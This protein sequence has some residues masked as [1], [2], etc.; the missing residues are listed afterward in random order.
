MT[1]RLSPSAPCA[2][3]SNRSRPEVKPVLMVL[4]GVVDKAALRDIGAVPHRAGGHGH[5]QRRLAPLDRWR[6][7]HARR[8]GPDTPSDVSAEMDVATWTDIVAGRAR[9][10][11]RSSTDASRSRATLNE[12]PQVRQS[13][14]GRCP[15][16][17]EARR[18]GCRRAEK[19]RRAWSTGL[20]S[21]ETRFTPPHAAAAASS[22]R[23]RSRARSGARSTTWA[24]RSRSSASSSRRPRASLASD[25]AHEFRLPGFRSGRSVP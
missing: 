16:L 17:I 5:R 3:A 13:A 23:W 25:V 20:R 18:F 1:I 14:V 19:S 22:T 2:L 11:R 8:A 7:L 10:R 15:L 4:A 12:G 6:R 21:C 9:S 24:G